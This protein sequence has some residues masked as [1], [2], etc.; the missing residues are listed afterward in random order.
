MNLDHLKLIAGPSPYHS[1][2]IPVSLKIP[3]PQD[4]PKAF[5]G[6]D[7]KA[8][9]KAL[10]AK[11][12]TWAALELRQVWADES[13]MRG[14]LKMAGVRVNDSNEPATCSRLRSL[15]RRKAI[16]GPETLDAVGTTIAGFLTLNQNLPLWAAVALILEAT[17]RYGPEVLA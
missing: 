10:E 9:R 11:R 13:H 14:F 7:P 2:F 6:C 15:L 16:T 4:L 5:L 1:L 3:L 8:G 12:A 17:G